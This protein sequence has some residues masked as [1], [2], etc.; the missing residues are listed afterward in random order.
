MAKANDKM[1]L[2]RCGR[3]LWI[4][5]VIVICTLLGALSLNTW[6]SISHR[7]DVRI[8]ALESSA[9]DLDRICNERTLKQNRR[10]RRN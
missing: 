1:S 2:V 4:P 5:G 8:L 3:S 7:E 9:R 6:H 10:W